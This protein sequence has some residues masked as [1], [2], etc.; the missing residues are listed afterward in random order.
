MADI[1]NVL[2]DGVQVVHR[3]PLQMEV[4]AKGH[5]KHGATHGSNDNLYMKAR[6]CSPSSGSMGSISFGVRIQASTVA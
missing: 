2:T 5:A 1:C 4:A 6:F 3:V